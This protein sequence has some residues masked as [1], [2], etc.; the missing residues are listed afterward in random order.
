MSFVYGNLSGF[1]DLALMSTKFDEKIPATPK[2]LREDS[3]ATQPIEED[4]CE[5][6]KKP[7]GPK[8]NYLLNYS[9][10]CLGSR[11]KA[12]VGVVTVESRL[13]VNDLLAVVVETIK[14]LKEW[15]EAEDLS[16]ESSESS[17]EEEQEQGSQSE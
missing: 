3:C 13:S 2:L 4:D 8:K 6:F 1:C 5:E 14:G 10:K 9:L 15:E 17:S 11:G 16:G 7:S 12:E